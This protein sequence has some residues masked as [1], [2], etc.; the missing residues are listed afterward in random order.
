MRAM[1]RLEGRQP[2]PLP[3]RMRLA[4]AIAACALAA[5]LLPAA[6]HAQDSAKEEIETCL[7]CHAD[8]GLAVTFAD[9]QSHTLKVDQAMFARSVHGEN[10]KCTDC[11]AGFGEIPHPERTFKNVADFR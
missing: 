4:A 9:G 1:L 7:T 3:T 6:V 10:L 5:G 11:H 8:D 2:P